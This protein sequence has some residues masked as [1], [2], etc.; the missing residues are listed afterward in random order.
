MVLTPWTISY[1][2]AAVQEASFGFSENA[3]SAKIVMGPREDSVSRLY[4][5]EF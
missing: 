5:A 3:A 4:S 2:A 1:S